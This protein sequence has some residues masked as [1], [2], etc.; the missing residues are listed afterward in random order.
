MYL[1]QDQYFTIE[2]NLQNKNPWGK[3]ILQCTKL[4]KKDILWCPEKSRI[5]RNNC[6]FK[7]TIVH[8]NCTA[9]YIAKYMLRCISDQLQRISI[10]KFSNWHKTFPLSSRQ[11]ASRH[12]IP[13]S[14]INIFIYIHIYIYI[15]ANSRLRRDFPRPPGEQRLRRRV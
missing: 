7:D 8:S 14:K 10:S 4:N 1:E 6:I 12:N 3:N 2:I 9:E 13:N 15:L 5:K 11:F